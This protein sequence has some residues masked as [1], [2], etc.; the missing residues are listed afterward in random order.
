MALREIRIHDCAEEFLDQQSEGTRERLLTIIEALSDDPF[1]DG[2]TKFVFPAPPVMLR[3]W[4]NATNWVVYH[5]DSNDIVHI[6]N[7]GRMLI[8]RISFRCR[9]YRPP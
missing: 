1:V 4:Y 5:L 9:R 2:E 8:D 3:V 7:I 6:Y